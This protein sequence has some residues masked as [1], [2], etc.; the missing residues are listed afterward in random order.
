M[1]FCACILCCKC[2]T[3]SIY[4]LHIVLICLYMHALTYALYSYLHI[5]QLI[6]QLVTEDPSQFTCDLNSPVG[7]EV[8]S[9]T[10]PRVSLTH[11]FCGQI[12]NPNTV[13]PIAKGVHGLGNGQ[14]SRNRVV[15]FRD[16][17]QDLVGLRSTMKCWRTTK[18]W[19]AGRP[20][21]FVT[22]LNPHNSEQLFYS[23]SFESTVNYLTSLYNNLNLVPC[24][25]L[26]PSRNNRYC[27]EIYNQ[28]T[29]T[30]DHKT[31]LQM[32]ANNNI[33]SAWPLRPNRNPYYCTT[34]NTCRVIQP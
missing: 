4:R 21:N 27:F 5:M 10:Q 6:Q 8:W 20:A 26:Q 29:N 34:Q 17:C 31:V 28:R 33:R 11:I 22:K 30:L 3:L 14:P 19:N 13:N 32:D 25:R 23:G 9:N 24:N 1:S 12:N 2:F 16:R 7:R 15:E 18:V